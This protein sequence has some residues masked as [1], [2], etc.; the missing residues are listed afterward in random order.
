GI[1]AHDDNVHLTSS[2]LY[3]T[4]V[5]V[6]T[7]M[8]LH[9]GHPVVLMDRWTP[10]GTLANIQNHHVTTSHMVPTHFTRML[11]LPEDVRGSYD[12]SSLRH[13]I[14]SAAPCP[15]DVK[16]RMF[17]WWGPVIYGYYAATEGG[18]TIA[19]PQDWLGHPGTVGKAWAG[20]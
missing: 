12:V 19:T 13:V 6:F 17:E 1:T 14:R 11:G 20:A 7:T 15:V 4:A 2:P 9:A 5:M 16:R 10:E 3:H 8:S 18:G